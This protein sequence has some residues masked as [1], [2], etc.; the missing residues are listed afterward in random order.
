[1]IHFCKIIFFT[2]FILLSGE[3]YASDCYFELYEGPLAKKDTL[4]NNMLAAEQG[5][6]AQLLAQK[7]LDTLGCK[8]LFLYQGVLQSVDSFQKRD[9][10]KLRPYFAEIPEAQNSLNRYQSNRSRVKNAAYV[11]TA[12]IALILVSIL[13]EEDFTD[14]DFRDALFFSGVG[15]TVGGFG[16]SFITL[17]QNEK[18][19]ERAVD[20]HNKKNP[21]KKIELKFNAGFV[22]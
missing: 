5:K 14:V 12:G 9:G 10:E 20:F 13:F 1:M 7:N 3:S 17:S 4:E 18:N 19:L 21:E 16:Y 8:R 6:K 2:L 22:F 11:G 15:L